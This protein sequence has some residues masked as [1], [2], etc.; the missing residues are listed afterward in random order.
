MR[1]WKAIQKWYE[2][3]D[4]PSKGELVQQELEG[5][6]SED[7]HLVNRQ[8][9]LTQLQGM[10]NEL[11]ALPGVNQNVKRIAD[12]QETIDNEWRLLK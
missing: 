5:L 7:Q 12:T 1:N 10:F 4:D 3:K 9:H 11:T 2:Q 6:T 8:K